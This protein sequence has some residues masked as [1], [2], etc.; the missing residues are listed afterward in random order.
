MIVIEEMCGPGINEGAWTRYVRVKRIQNQPA[1]LLCYFQ[2]L[3][4]YTSNEINRQSLLVFQLQ[5]LGLTRDGGGTTCLRDW[6]MIGQP[7]P[8]HQDTTKV[9]TRLRMYFI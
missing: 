8:S 7:L 5:Q 3:S 2:N 1:Q 4:K 6:V 9:M